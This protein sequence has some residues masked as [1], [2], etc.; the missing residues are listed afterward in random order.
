MMRWGG[1][2]KYRCRVVEY[3]LYASLEGGKWYRDE[4]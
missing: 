2:E 4:L 1:V 3:W